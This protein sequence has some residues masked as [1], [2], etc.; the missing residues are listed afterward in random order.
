[1]EVNYAVSVGGTQCNLG[2]VTADNR[3]YEAALSWYGQ[4]I[5]TLNLVLSK[6]PLRSTARQFLR[7]TYEGRSY[8]LTKLRRYSEALEDCV[9]AL[10]FDNGQHQHQIQLYRAAT[11]ARLKQHTRAAAV[12]NAL[13]GAKDA[14]AGNVYDAACVFALSAAATSDDAKQTDQ[15]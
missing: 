9:H 14:S 6:H 10:E 13:A 15:Y 4:A 2:H 5:A 8:T 3:Q 7:N 1:M 11:L 12:A